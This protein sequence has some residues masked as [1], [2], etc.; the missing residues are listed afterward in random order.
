MWKLKNAEYSLQPMKPLVPAFIG[1]F[2][3]KVPPDLKEWISLEMPNITELNNGICQRGYKPAKIIL[4]Y[5]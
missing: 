2:D 4:D 5:L 1:Q 3:S